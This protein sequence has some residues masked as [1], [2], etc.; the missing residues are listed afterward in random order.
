MNKKIISILMFLGTMVSSIHA[1]NNCSLYVLCAFNRQED[2]L[3]KT[4]GWADAKGVCRTS[5]YEGDHSDEQKKSEELRRRVKEL[6]FKCFNDGGEA[7]F[8]EQK[9]ADTELQ[10][11]ESFFRN[12]DGWRGANKK[13]KDLLENNTLTFSV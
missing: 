11:V 4:D 2:K 5:D 1:K 13:A 7:S 3:Y 6:T 12:R 9:Y 8:I 10:S